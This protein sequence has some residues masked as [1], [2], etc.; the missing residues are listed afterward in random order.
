MRFIAKRKDADAKNFDEH[1]YRDM[2]PDLEHFKSGRKLWEHFERHGRGEGRFASLEDARTFLRRQG[3]ELPA[4]FDPALYR[5]INPDLQRLYKRDWQYELHYLKFGAAEGREYRKSSETPNFPWESVFNYYE[6][7]LHSASWRIDQKISQADAVVLFWDQGV[8]RLIPLQCGWEF[9]PVFY[10][11][12][13]NIAERDPRRLY[14]LWLQEGFAAG[15]APNPHKAIYGLVGDREYPNCFDWRQFGGMRLNKIAALETFFHG[16]VSQRFVS[17]PGAA[18]LHSAV[19]DYHLVRGA[20]ANAETAYALAKARGGN[21]AK[22]HLTHGDSLRHLGRKEPALKAYRD[23][24]AHTNHSVWALFHAA[25]LTLDAGDHE[26]AFRLLAEGRRRWS[27]NLAYRRA[28]EDCIEQRFR[29]ISDAIRSELQNG[30]VPAANAVGDRDLPTLIETIERFTVGPLSPIAPVGKRIVM[31]AC[32]D[33]KQCTHY[34]VEQKKEQ[35]ALLGFELEVFDFNHPAAFMRNLPGATAAIFYRVPCYPKIVQSILYARGLGVPTY[36]EI[37]DLVFTTDFPDTFESYAN[38]IS[39]DEYIGLRHGVPLYR[40]AIKLCS[41]GIA[42]TEPLADKLKELVEAKTAFVV[43][44]GLDSRSIPAIEIGSFRRPATSS[45][46]IFYGSGTR[47]HNDDFNQLA[48]PAL[49]HAMERFKDVRLIIVGHLALDPAFAAFED[50]IDR[51]QFVEN[52]NQYWSLLAMADVNIAVLHCNPMSHCKSEIKWLEAAVLGVPSI[53]SPTATYQAVIDAPTEGLFASTVEE[54]ID[55]FDKLLADA[56]LRCA[57]GRAARRK[58][59]EKYTLPQ[60]SKALEEGLAP[61][62]ASPPSQPLEMPQGKKRI[63]IVNVYF[64]P[65]T[66]G[67]A[68]RVVESNIDTLLE[69][70]GERYDVSLFATDHG[71]MPGAFSIDSYKGCPVF[72]IGT[73]AEVN[74]DWRGFNTDNEPLFERVLDIV[75]PDL[76]HFHA[77]QRLTASIVE[78][79]LKRAIPYVVTLHDAWWISDH[80]FLTDQHGLLVESDADPFV[81]LLPDQVTRLQSLE[82]GRRLRGVL[83]RARYALPVSKSF[84]DIYR[85]A[86]LS[87]LRVITNGI[88]ILPKP[89]PPSSRPDKLVLGHIGGRSVHKG[90][91]LLEI[92]LKANAFENLSLLMIDMS[93]D[94]GDEITT[95]WGATPVTF[96]GMVPQSEVDKLFASFDVLVAPSTWPESF[97]LVT[98]EAAFYNKWIVCSNLGAIAD[99]VEHGVNGFSVDVSDTRGLSSTLSAMDLEWKRFKRAPDLGGKTFR[100]SETQGNEIAALYDEILGEENLKVS[101][102]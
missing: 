29:Q 15:H 91:S 74:M 14:R 72:R 61:A 45:V 102:D 99:D 87:N 41:Y 79:T 10:R 26:G 67:G 4:D 95:K 35:L 9:D 97:G 86:G 36:Y 13:F 32:L 73:P 71:A 22:L 44:N 6:F 58:A 77:I 18:A 27:G 62:L 46:S 23:S 37:D 101:K 89:L 84:E 8:D 25:T 34:R 75:K 78:V 92:T 59:L 12:Q 49:L 50:R 66:Q 47:A 5:Q 16:P 40:N 76:V 31:L 90:A 28:V 11:D 2:Y 19:G 70:H 68:T 63:L 17:D 30:D 88:S 56:D 43:P 85:K 98:R 57:I 33:L 38:Q 3:R 39:P 60:I 54:W 48:G 94:A 53:V 93:I 24:L 81:S 80:Q 64:A 7:L 51:F 83:Q 55:A 100:T 52:L 20:F 21:D 42:S 65:Q 82:R 69:H 96:R 1:F